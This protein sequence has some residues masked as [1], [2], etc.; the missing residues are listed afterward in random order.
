MFGSSGDGFPPIV[1]RRTAARLACSFPCCSAIL[2]FAAAFCLLGALASPW[3]FTSFS[4]KGENEVTIFRYFYWDGMHTSCNANH[5]HGCDPYGELTRSSPWNEF[6]SQDFAV[7]YMVCQALAF[8]GFVLF[9]GYAVFSSGLHLLDAYA[10][11][12]PAK[13]I[14]VSIAIVAFA[15]TVVSWALFFRTSRLFEQHEAYFGCDVL[16]DTSVETWCD[17]AFLG[18]SS[19]EPDLSPPLT[20]HFRWGPFVGWALAVLA[21]LP[22]INVA[23]M[24]VF[25][26]ADAPPPMGK[27]LQRSDD[28]D[29]RSTTYGAADT[30]GDH[31]AT[32]HSMDTRSPE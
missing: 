11:L 12:H 30:R 27:S 18:Y 31:L 20:E 4:T 17:G 3:Y 26:R 8:V 9:I 15:S 1:P 21:T 16:E 7:T 24:G 32:T 14:L 25:I 2:A 23:V 28:A 6:P 22:A 19:H 10:L 5:H 29:G 13:W